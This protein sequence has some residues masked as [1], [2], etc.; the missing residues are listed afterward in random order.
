MHKICMSF[1]ILGLKS[2]IW[3]Q[4]FNWRGEIWEAFKM[5]LLRGLNLEQWG[6]RIERQT[7]KQIWGRLRSDGG[8]GGWGSGPDERARP[9]WQAH[10]A[11]KRVWEKMQSKSLPKHCASL[12]FG[13]IRSA[14]HLKAMAI[15]TN[16][17]NSELQHHGSAIAAP[18]PARHSS[19][20]SLFLSSYV[21][22]EFAHVVFSARI[23][24]MDGADN[25]QMCCGLSFHIVSWV[26]IVSCRFPGSI[27]AFLSREFDHLKLPDVE[28]LAFCGRRGWMS[29]LRFVRVLPNKKMW[30]SSVFLPLLPLCGLSSSSGSWWWRTFLSRGFRARLKECVVCS[31]SIWITTYV[32]GMFCAR[33]ESG[34]SNLPR[35]CSWI[36]VRKLKPVLLAMLQLFSCCVHMKE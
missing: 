20:S 5:K 24:C 4:P 18:R 7:F 15:A 29:H 19:K 17:R 13:A 1:Y 28:F 2:W 25:V 30:I 33:F 21:A 3:I 34:G 6:Q 11:R 32:T 8:G 27:L 35:R 23:L 31:V 9:T 16:W 36:S 22:K 26:A 12:R 10:E 14:E